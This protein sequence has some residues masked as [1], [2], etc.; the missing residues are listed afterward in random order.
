MLSK[1]YVV[2][3]VMVG[4][5]SNLLSIN[6]TINT[7]S[8]MQ[9]VAKQTRSAVSCIYYNNAFNGT[10]TPKHETEVNGKIT[11]MLSIISL[12]VSG[13]I[14]NI[15]NQD[16]R[17]FFIPSSYK[18]FNVGSGI[19]NLGISIGSLD[20][21]NAIL[22]RTL[23][24]S[25]EDDMEISVPLKHN[26]TGFVNEETKDIFQYPLYLTVRA[27]ALNEEVAALQE[28]IEELER[29]SKYRGFDGLDEA[30]ELDDLGLSL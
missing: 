20:D 22:A 3:P 30:D 16:M 21:S 6:N 17:N 19:Y 26:K 25:K 10:V 2:I 28:E 15:D 14:R 7:F 5:S 27:N 13:T 8:S 29:N 11:K 23:L 12:M 1:D 4:D 24:S 9:G 18:T